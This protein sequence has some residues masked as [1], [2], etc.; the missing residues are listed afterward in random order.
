MPS[1]CAPK[2]AW[3]PVKYALTILASSNGMA[4]VRSRLEPD[5]GSAMYGLAGAGDVDRG[6]NGVH[7]AKEAMDD[8]T[9]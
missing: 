8:L 6:G 1:S 7:A 9:Y 2:P 3:G 4:A 5:Q